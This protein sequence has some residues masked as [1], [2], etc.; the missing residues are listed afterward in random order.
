MDSKAENEFF[1]TWEFQEKM[2]LALRDDRYVDE[3]G[4]LI[5]DDDNPNPNPDY[6][7][8]FANVMQEGIRQ[9]KRLNYDK[10]RLVESNL[11]RG[12]QARDWMWKQMQI[13]ETRKR[14]DREPWMDWRNFENW[15]DKGKRVRREE[16]DI[17][18]D[19]IEILDE[20]I[21]ENVPEPARAIPRI[22]IP[23]EVNNQYYNEYLARRAAK[24]LIQQERRRAA[25]Q[26]KI[27]RE[28]AGTTAREAAI[29]KM[30]RGGRRYKKRRRYRRKY[31]GRRRWYGRG[32]YRMNAGDSFGTRW[33]GYLG[34]K[35]GEF[36]GGW[37]QRAIGL[38]DYNVSKNVFSGRLPEMTNIAGNGG[39][40]VRFQEY[41]GDVVSSSTAGAFKIDSYLLN[42][43]NEK[44][45]P[46]LSQIAANYDQ[47]EFQGVIFEFRS[48]SGNALTSTNTA[49]GTLMMA[50]QYDIVDA[51]FASK[52]EMLNYEFS[53]S[54]V[55]SVSNSH[56]IECDPHQ[57][58]LPLL[59][60]EPGSTNPANTDPRLYFLGRFQIATVG[61]QGVNVN[62]GELHVTYQVKLLKPKLVTTLGLTNQTYIQS[63]T[64]VST[65]N[66]FGLDYEDIYDNGPFG[67]TADKQVRFGDHPLK[68]T[69]Y[70]SIIWT[71]TVAS[72]CVLPSITGQNG[73]TVRALP[74]SFYVTGN[75]SLS[76]NMTYSS[77]VDVQNVSNVGNL[78]PTL[79]AAGTGGVFPIGTTSHRIIITE[80]PNNV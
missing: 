1:S 67:R 32:D 29:S 63:F 74:Y 78:T 11:S 19:I 53:T 43:A 45:F 66:P 2:E 22:D 48:T 58:P 68:K 8:D 77:F 35:G 12:D 4:Y 21:E 9:E 17:D 24:P 61:F 25:A 41:L 31:G 55:P 75:G 79:D 3:K 62:C 39:T 36:L 65:N 10:P 52:I 73:C 72:N 14:R 27:E 42:A 71:G 64:N 69:Y 40:V 13:E 60:T 56:M 30:L 34:S 16:A 54:T 76:A 18:N 59:Y 20:M 46:W 38:G 15:I 7:Q 44:T 33:G 47:F 80:L 23:M 70:V 26:A 51:P 57:T 28:T 50:T 37:A 5:F 6:W 49:L